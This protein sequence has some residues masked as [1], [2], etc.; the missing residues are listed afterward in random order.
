MRIAI[1]SD[2]HGNRTAFEAV[3]ADLQHTSPDLVLH[4]GDLADFGANSAD[5]VDRIRDL[6]W[7][8]VIGN[9]EEA[10]SAP[11]TLE[12]FAANSS[13]P[14]SLWAAIRE[15]MSATRELLGSDRIE[16]LRG[17]PRIH[18]H[19][20]TVLVHATP[21]STWRSPGPAASDSELMAAYEPLQQPIV[22]YGHIH[23]SFIRTVS[24][25]DMKLVIANSGSVSLSY[26][27]DHRAAYLLLDGAQPSIR[28]VDYDLN[29]EI[30]ALYERGLPHADWLA[31]TLRSA[32]PQMPSSSSTA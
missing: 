31:N 7:Q 14:A 27:G 4:G 21:E 20:R 10:L 2:V 12:E 28:R 13:A 5:I 22:V 8:G 24:T 17:L 26:D 32:Y 11:E 1:L 9:C 16:W 3:L 25:T 6:G 15:I 29:E 30:Q 19:D 18:V 23:R